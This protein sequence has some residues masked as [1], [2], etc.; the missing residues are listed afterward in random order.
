M[1]YKVK[2]FLDAVKGM[3][4]VEAAKEQKMTPDSVR[5][6]KEACL[7]GRDVRV[8]YDGQTPVCRVTI[9]YKS[10]VSSKRRKPEVIIK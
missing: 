6:R 8:V 5:K 9:D 3:T 2:N 1:K 4:L 10:L 7:N